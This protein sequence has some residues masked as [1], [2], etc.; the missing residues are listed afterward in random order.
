MTTNSRQFWHPAAAAAECSAPVVV[1]IEGCGQAF[2]LATRIREIIAK[3]RLQEGGRDIIVRVED[4]PGRGNA[5]QALARVLRVLEAAKPPGAVR[6]FKTEGPD[7]CYACM[8]KRG[9]HG[10]C[11]RRAQL[12][13]PTGR[14]K[15]TA[16]RS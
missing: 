1:A 2:Q 10:W 15:S 14:W 11:G 16:C 3:H 6:E 12:R 7:A 4:P 13:F 5:R 9:S 8:C